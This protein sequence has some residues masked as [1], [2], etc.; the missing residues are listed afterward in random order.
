VDVI[1]GGPPCQGFSTVRQ[2]DGANH[3]ERLVE[4]KRRTLYQ[5]FLKYVAFFKPRVFVME[6]VLGIRTASGGEYFTRVQREARDLGYRVHAKVEDCTELGLPQKRRRQ[7]FIGTRLDIAPYFP[8]QLQPAPGVSTQPTLW[9]AI[10][11]LPPLHAGEGDEE[12]DYDLERRKAHVDRIGREYTY[13]VLEVQK[14]AKLTAHRAR[15]HSE[16]DLR[17]F[18]RLRE[19]ES[20]AAAMRRGVKFEFP[21][22]KTTF[23]DRYTRQSRNEPCSTIVAHLNRDGLMFI[24]PTQN[25]SLTV[26][27]AA[28]IQSFPDWFVLPVARTHQ[29]R[30]IGNAVPP[31]VSEAVGHAVKAYIEKTADANAYTHLTLDPVPANERQAAEWL[32]PLLDLK[33]R[34]LRH[35]DGYVFKR[36]WYA[37]AFL[38]PCLHPDNTKDNGPRQSR[39][40]E[41]GGA[42]RSVDPRLASPCFERS[43]W[44]VIL[45]P[46]ADEAW[47]RFLADEFT[48]AEFYCS[49]AQVAG[50]RWRNRELKRRA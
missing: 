47:R 48:D 31:L 38:Y 3:G 50:M 14:A 8:S 49:D 42:A 2:T 37:I 34:E 44:P 5:E 28:R 7:L 35:V 12:A 27:E 13:G 25:R 36:G 45:A 22:D 40:A 20:S 32:V 24:H 18:M 10:G 9:D 30:L 26:R 19:G 41:E 16:R 21:Y 11:D 29:Y 15:P 23:T 17:D 46:V 6:N 4:D 39:S 43:G 1:V 33:T